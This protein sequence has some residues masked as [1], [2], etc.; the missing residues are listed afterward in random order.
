MCYSKRV[1]ERQAP[2][3]SG[4]GVTTLV[5]STGLRAASLLALV[6]SVSCSA[7]DEPALDVLVASGCEGEAYAVCDP[8]DAG[9]QARI[10]SGVRCLR[11]MPDAVIPEVRS[12]TAGQYKAELEASVAAPSDD[13]GDE[14]PSTLALERV[15]AL[16]E[17]A[18]PG[19]LSAEALV[20]LYV[21]TVPGYYSAREDRVTLIEPPPGQPG[22]L[23]RDA[24]LLAHEFTH[25]L[26]DQDVDL[27]TLG[28]GDQTFDEYLALT[29]VIEG[30]AAMLESFFEAAVWGLSGE[31]DFRSHFVSWVERAEE[32]YGDQSPLSVGPRYFPYSYGARYV[33]NV[34]D[35]GGTEAVRKLY[36][37]LPP[38][39]LPMLLSV[40]ELVQ[41][42]LEPLSDLGLPDAPDGFGLRVED[43]L[44][45]WV[46]SRFLER[47]LAT[48]LAQELAGHW[49]ADRFLVYETEAGGVTGV[50]MLR[51]DDAVAAERCVTVLESRPGASLP[52]LSFALRS[53][54]DVALAVT[55]PLSSS[56][57]W[58]AALEATQSGTSAAG[59]PRDGLSLE[60]PT[61]RRL[62]G[63]AKRRLLRALRDD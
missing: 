47:G 33:Y 2:R 6:V 11:G 62:S 26:Q 56:A 40:D 5:S 50:W 49:R 24:L 14:T 4:A 46:F 9:C 32:H 36:G 42:E 43:A 7:A 3:A 8:F 54:R 1:L 22:D 27:A 44:G 57:G 31:P 18:T 20:T 59:S 21:D 28:A 55:D 53:D 60:P 16:L 29:S 34:Y 35:A 15:L 48:P 63:A 17:L 58:Q 30:E 37:Q 19:E 61:G 10:F 41:P 25:A 45:P 52:G 23:F 12:I 51:F 13:P 38:S 39:V